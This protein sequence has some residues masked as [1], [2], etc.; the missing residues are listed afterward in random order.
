MENKTLRH[1]RTGVGKM[2]WQNCSALEINKNWGKSGRQRES[3]E[4]EGKWKE[5]EEIKQRSR[6]WN[7]DWLKHRPAVSKNVFYFLCSN[8]VPAGHLIAR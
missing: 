6:G 2:K 5:R 1:G 4:I 3:A 7:P 8:R